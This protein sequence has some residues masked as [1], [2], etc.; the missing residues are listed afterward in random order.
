MEH[1][2]GVSYTYKCIPEVRGGKTEHEIFKDILVEIFSQFN[3]NSQPMVLR[4][5]AKKIIPQDII[6]IMTDYSSETT[7]ARRQ[8]NDIFECNLSM[9][10]SIFSKNPFQKKVDK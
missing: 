8:Q 9:Q 2:Q 7:E 4:C 6:G 1:Y 3:L 5:Y 10:N